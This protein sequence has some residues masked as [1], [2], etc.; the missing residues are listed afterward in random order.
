MR[1][2]QLLTLTTYKVSKHITSP[3]NWTVLGH[4]VS[5]GK[6]TRDLARANVK[7]LYRAGS[8]RTVSR[9]LGLD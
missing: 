9:E 4:N 2:K 1:C 3:R 6:G 5:S 7:S 8:L